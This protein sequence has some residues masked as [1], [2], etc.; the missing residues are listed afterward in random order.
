M[1]HP[2]SYF[3]FCPHCG[4]EKFEEYDFKSK[5][6]AACGFT[7]Y[8]NIAAATACFIRN[9]RGELLI[10]RRKKEPAKGT[11]DLP[12][13]FVDMDESGEAAICREIEEETGLHI[14]LPHFLFSLPNIYLYSG[15]EIHTLDLFFE[16][17]IPENDVP[18]ASDDVSELTFLP[19]NKI[20][21][22][23]FGLSSIKRAMDI[24]LKQKKAT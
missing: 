8:A 3:R 17:T 10:A 5:R 7:Y 22:A 11:L 18:I 14:A 24:Y 2:L 6:C 9:D 20:D 16:T 19:L 1:S 4:S 13:G 23:L 15:M 12:G 21:P